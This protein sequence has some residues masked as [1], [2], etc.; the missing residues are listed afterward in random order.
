MYNILYAKIDSILLSLSLNII[1]Q[2]LRLIT[3]V[4][5]NPFQPEPKQEAKA[6]LPT[7]FLPKPHLFNY[8]SLFF[9][10]K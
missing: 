2:K 5:F 7:S 4:S 6:L 1:L 3:D 10:Y 9:I 8:F